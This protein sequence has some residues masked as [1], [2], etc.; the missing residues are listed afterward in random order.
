MEES[1]PIRSVSGASLGQIIRWPPS[2]DAKAHSHPDNRY[3][4]VISGTFYHGYG[5]KFDVKRLEVRPVGT[6]FT[7]PAGVGHFGAT[8][9]EGAVL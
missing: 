7:E 1:L 8:K 2:T 9:D 4:F 5:D 3:G 6:F